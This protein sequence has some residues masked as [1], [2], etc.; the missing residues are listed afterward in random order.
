M[1][2]GLQYVPDP[3]IS[4]VH[5]LSVLFCFRLIPVMKSEITLPMEF[6]LEVLASISDQSHI[7]QYRSFNSTPQP[8]VSLEN[9]YVNW[10]IRFEG[11]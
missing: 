3:P 6:Q 1:L 10:D 2:E 8:F 5:F 7:S 4:P 11:L 9:E